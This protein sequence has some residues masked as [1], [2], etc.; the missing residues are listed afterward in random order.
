MGGL[1]VKSLPKFTASY[2][3][4]NNESEQ[5][6]EVNVTELHVTLHSAAAVDG[7]RKL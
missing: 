3:L 6:I 1:L 4:S 7:R 2:F 5:Y